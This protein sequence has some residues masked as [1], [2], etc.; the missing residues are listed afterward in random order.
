[1]LV[2]LLGMVMDFRPEHPEYLQVTVFQWFLVKTVEKWWY[3]FS[4]RRKTER[5]NVFNLCL[6]TKNG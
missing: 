2:T 4:G 1:M 3:G 6:G 5:F